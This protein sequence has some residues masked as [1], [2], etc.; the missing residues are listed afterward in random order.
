LKEMCSK[1]CDNSYNRTG[2]SSQMQWLCHMIFICR[3]PVL[4]TEKETGLCYILHSSAA[5]INKWRED[6]KLST[7]IRKMYHLFI[8]RLGEVRYHLHPTINLPHQLILDSVT[9]TCSGLQYG[10]DLK[11][12][13]FTN[14][15]LCYQVLHCI[16]CSSL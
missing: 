1:T 12:K 4:R 13:R 3:E 2:R 11:L 16:N 14:L 5:W 8:K 9:S 15:K 10:L 7:I 6:F